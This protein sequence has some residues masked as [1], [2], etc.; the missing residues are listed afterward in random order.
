MKLLRST[1]PVAAAVTLLVNACAPAPHKTSAS[2]SAGTTSTMNTTDTAADPYLWLEDVTGDKALDWVRQQNA[3]STNELTAA[4][5]FEKTRQ[6]LLT[7]LDSKE[8][9]PMVSKYGRH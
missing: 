5:E 4:P 3:Q 9:I 8:R 7:I 6:Q 2:R 1:L